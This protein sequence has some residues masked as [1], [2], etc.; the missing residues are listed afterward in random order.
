[1][2][3]LLKFLVH[4]VLQDNFSKKP[5]GNAGGYRIPLLSFPSFHLPFSTNIFRRGLNTKTRHQLQS[6]MKSI[7]QNLDINTSSIVSA[8]RVASNMVDFSSAS[9]PASSPV[10]FSTSGRKRKQTEKAKGEENRPI[11]KQKLPKVQKQF[12]CSNCHKVFPTEAR[13]IIH[14]NTHKAQKPYPCKK[15]SKQFANPNG[16]A[17]HMLN[18][19]GEKPHGCNEC[20][21]RFTQASDLTAH[22]RTHTGEKPFKCDECG[23]LFTRKSDLNKHMRTHTGEKPYKCSQCSKCFSNQNGLKY[24]MHN[25]TGE[26]PY[27]CNFCIKTFSR[28]GDLK[29]HARSHQDEV[30]NRGASYLQYSSGNEGTHRTS[31]RPFFYLF[32]FVFAS[33]KYAHYIVSFF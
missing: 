30:V 11:Q 18:H 4:I 27:Q 22:T 8:A 5:Q 12:P 17:Y 13:L 24:H 26:K 20:G 31:F 21:K 6:S 14:S 28:K 2:C 29:I 7:K 15:C 32:R 10:N 9:G 23:K 33:C 19:K 25:H 3:T 16:L 1:M